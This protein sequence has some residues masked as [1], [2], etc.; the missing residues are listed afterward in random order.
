MT[1]HPPAP[2]QK[3][4]VGRVYRGLWFF[5]SSSPPLRQNLSLKKLFPKPLWRE[6]PRRT[7]RGFWKIGYHKIW[8]QDCLFQLQDT[9]AAVSAGLFQRV[10]SQRG[11]FKIFS[12]LDRERWPVLWGLC[13]ASSVSGN[14]PQQLQQPVLTGSV[15]PPPPPPCAFCQVCG[16]VKLLYFI[17]ICLPG[18]SSSCSSL[19][20]SNS[21]KPNNP[22]PPKNPK[23]KNN[24]PNK[25]P[26]AFS[27]VN[28]NWSKLS[29]GVWPN[30]GIYAS[31]RIREPTKGSSE[32]VWWG[33]GR[34][35][36]IPFLAFINVL[37]LCLKLGKIGF[38]LIWN[39][40]FTEKKLWLMM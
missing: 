8:P 4:V 27:E 5:S 12:S 32:R 35:H 17:V 6:R 38:S 28:H 14:T 34:K 20:T 11:P 33:G 15:S 9:K 36:T 16:W 21:Q 22:P 1:N 31:T 10:V 26:K 40:I 24:Q 2:S 18:A 30:V 23:S 19:S 25:K 29:M 3:G 39:W 13:R 37:M 7:S